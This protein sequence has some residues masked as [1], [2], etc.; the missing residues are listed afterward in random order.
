MAH[1]QILAGMSDFEA[2]RSI[3]FNLGGEAT[4][5]GAAGFGEDYLDSNQL[6]GCIPKSLGN[7]KELLYLSIDDN[8]LSG[9]IPAELMALTKLYDG[10]FDL[11]N[12][13]LYTQNTDLK[14]FLN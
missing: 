11:R 13:H 14:S 12:N 6:W 3:L 7:C 5:V 9:E 1:V 2:V 8:E 10:E 4:G